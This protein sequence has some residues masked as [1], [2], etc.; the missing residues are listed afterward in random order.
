MNQFRLAFL[1]WMLGLL[2]AC[3]RGSLNPNSNNKPPTASFTAGNTVQVG[4]PL[5][6]DG[7]PSSDPDSDALAFS[8]NF[9]DGISGETSKIA[10][11]FASSGS[12]KV[13]LTV[14]DGKGGT[15][16][17]EKTITVTAGPAPSKTASA[18]AVV[19]NTGGAPLAGVTLKVVGS[20]N[21]ATTDASGKAGDVVALR[22]VA[23]S[24]TSPR[25][26][27]LKLFKSGQTTALI[28]D[29]IGN[30][31]K[32]LTE[33]AFIAKAIPETGVYQAEVDPKQFCQAFLSIRVAQPIILDA[34]T[35]LGTIQKANEAAVF[36]FQ[37]QSGQ[38]FGAGA[39]AGTYTLT[40]GEPV[41]EPF[42]ARQGAY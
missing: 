30:Q 39:T 14:G 41:K 19:T 34:H 21:N 15:H 16:T 12:S 24:N 32:D 9:G 38:V 3:G 22:L 27:S 29:T 18:Q 2:G 23:N 17:V 40:L 25:S 7:S 6:L 33:G 36:R 20:N 5:V 4:I 26:G 10:H 11:I 13:K 1:L 31:E 8:W 35:S 42:C 28:T 37:G